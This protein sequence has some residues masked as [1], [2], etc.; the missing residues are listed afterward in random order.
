M[1]DS[2]GQT[3]GLMFLS[4]VAGAIVGSVLGI[5]FAPKSGAETRKDLAKFAADAKKETERITKAAVDRIEQVVDEA[6][7]A[8]SKKAAGA[9]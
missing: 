6:Q 9:K 3:T 2:T 1:S 8:L 7:K 5:L 4:F